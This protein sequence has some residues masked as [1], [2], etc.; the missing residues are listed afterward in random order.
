MDIK[1]HCKQVLDGEVMFDTRDIFASK[2][3]LFTYINE[4]VENWKN[5]QADAAIIKMPTE[6]RVGTKVE[7][8]VKGCDDYEFL[9][10]EDIVFHKI[11]QLTFS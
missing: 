9:E 10:I 8:K 5:M 11:F 1:I 4:I 7:L 6:F 3:E 2:E